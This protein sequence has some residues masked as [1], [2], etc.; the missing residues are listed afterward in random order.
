MRALSFEARVSMS[1]FHFPLRLLLPLQIQHVLF[2]QFSRFLVEPCQQFSASSFS[3]L[4]KRCFMERDAAVRGRC[5]RLCLNLVRSSTDEFQI[6]IGRDSILLKHA[7]SIF[8]RRTYPQFVLITR[9]AS[10]HHE[11]FLFGP[12]ARLDAMTH[13]A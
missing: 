6:P 8:T 12:N 7:I 10:C 2:L 5:T 13:Y 9:R 1:R 4:S 3:A 11:A